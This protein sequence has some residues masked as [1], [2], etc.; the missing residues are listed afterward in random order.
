MWSD[1]LIIVLLKLIPSGHYGTTSVI[2]CVHGAMMP[3]K[4]HECHNGVKGTYKSNTLIVIEGLQE[5]SSFTSIIIPI[6]KDVLYS[7]FGPDLV[8][9]TVA[10]L[11][12]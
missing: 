3:I 9:L 10:V 8:G 11:E 7:M 4:F 6:I 5:L 12:Q 2:M 1:N